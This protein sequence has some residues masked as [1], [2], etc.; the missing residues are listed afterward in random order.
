M[1][2][3]IQIE[4][5]AGKLLRMVIAALYLGRDRENRNST[6]YDYAWGGTTILGSYLIARG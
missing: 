5:R 4:E 2:T 3:V 6:R 1:P